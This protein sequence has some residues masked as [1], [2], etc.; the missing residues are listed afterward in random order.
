MSPRNPR[1]R[2]RFGNSSFVLLLHFF[3]LVLVDGLATGT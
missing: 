1:F 3:E 2:L